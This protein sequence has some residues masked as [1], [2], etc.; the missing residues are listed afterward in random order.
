M[1]LFEVVRRAHPYRELHRDEFEEAL[2]LLSEG[3]EASRGR[4]RRLPAARPGAGT[5]SGAA[6]CADDCDFEWRDDSGYGALCGD[7]AAGGSA[8]CDAG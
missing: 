4:Y 3:I 6:W 2:C 7:R 1:R 8:D 5:H